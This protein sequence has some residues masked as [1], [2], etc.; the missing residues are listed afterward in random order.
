MQKGREYALLAFLVPVLVPIGYN[1]SPASGFRTLRSGFTDGTMGN[2]TREGERGGAD[3]SALEPSITV[4]GRKE[5]R[6]ITIP[7]M[8]FKYIPASTDFQ[9][10]LPF[11]N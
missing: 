2:D 8:K 7:S 6:R 4:R 10:L 3:V 11:V 1:Q 9:F 5:G